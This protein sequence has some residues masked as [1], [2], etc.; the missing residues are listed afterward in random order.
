[1]YD[2]HDHH[3]HLKIFYE[4]HDFIETVMIVMNCIDTIIA[5]LCRCVCSCCC[6]CCCCSDVGFPHNNSYNNTEQCQGH[7]NILPVT[8]K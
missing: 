8:C 7:A 3:D 1:M 5:V 6:C 4:G 2:D